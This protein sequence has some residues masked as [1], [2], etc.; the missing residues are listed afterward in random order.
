MSDVKTVTREIPN[1]ERIKGE[2]IYKYVLP[3]EDCVEVAMPMNA[4]PIC[5]QVQKGQV[6]VWA[7]VSS[8]FSTSGRKFYF[9]GTGHDMPRMAKKYLGTVQ[10]SED[11]LVYHIYTEY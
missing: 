9:V 1:D 4:I 6:C 3:V 8:R 5:V 11:L 2:K 10:L 7:Q